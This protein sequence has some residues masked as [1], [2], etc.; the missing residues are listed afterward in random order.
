MSTD[1][2]RE[3]IEEPLKR[4]FNFNKTQILKSYILLDL[5]ST[6]RLKDMIEKR[7]LLFILTSTNQ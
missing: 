2:W 3:K 6:E 7:K 4:S 5:N 1:E